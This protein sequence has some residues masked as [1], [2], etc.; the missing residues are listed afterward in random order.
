MRNGQLKPGY[1]L[2]I[3]TENQFVLH[4]DTIMARRIATWCYRFHHIKYQ[5]TQ[6]DFQ[7]EI[8]VY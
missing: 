8:K 6:T 3:A 2:Q 7:Q 1:N 5:K 4:I